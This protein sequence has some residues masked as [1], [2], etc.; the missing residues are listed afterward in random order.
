RRQ[1]VQE[2][3]GSMQELSEQDPELDLAGFLELVTLQTDADTQDGAED[4][5]TLMTVHAAKGLEFP[6]VIVAGLE[7]KTF[8]F[9]RQ[10][11]EEPF[12]QLEEERRLAYVAFTR[13]Q[14][15]LFL[16]YASSRRLF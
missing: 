12:E 2:L 5:L 15:R 13:A 16:T 4:R 6:A 7:E 10:D 14:E 3:L 11:E 1:N 9:E 8:P